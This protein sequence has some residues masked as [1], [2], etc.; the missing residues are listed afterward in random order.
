MPLLSTDVLVV[1]DYKQWRHFILQLLKDMKL[2]VVGEAS[3]GLEAVQKAEELQPDVV[4]LDIGLPRL[5][6]IEAA[7]QIGVASPKSK[8]LFFSENSSWDIVEEAMRIGAGGFVVKS[9]AA[10]DLR[11]AIK[12]ILEGERFLSSSLAKYAVEGSAWQR[13]SLT[14]VLL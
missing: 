2:R 7:R 8:I 9:D 10:N 6:G 1:D 12:A 5:N 4:V 11:A 14:N 13:S 3:D